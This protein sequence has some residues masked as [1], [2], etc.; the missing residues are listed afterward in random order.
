MDDHA[1]ER[2]VELVYELVKR[3]ATSVIFTPTERDKAQRVVDAYDE[4]RI[5]ADGLVTAVVA[6]E[7]MDWPEGGIYD[8]LRQTHLHGR[9]FMDVWR[10]AD[11]STRDQ[12]VAIMARGR[13]LLGDEDDD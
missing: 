4:G 3:R 13:E 9:P 12:F 11:E 2:S 10:E 6:L 1:Y 7:H 8:V 5:D